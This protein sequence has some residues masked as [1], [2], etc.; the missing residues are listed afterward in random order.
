MQTIER[1]GI[2]V[3]ALELIKNYLENRINLV[4]IDNFK[5]ENIK[6]TTGVPQGTVLGPLFFI[7]YVNDLLKNMPQN[8]IAYADDTVV[9]STTDCWTEAS[10]KMNKY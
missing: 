3:S 2:R 5:S 10:A 4:K 6:M 1:H 7:I 8:L 9:L